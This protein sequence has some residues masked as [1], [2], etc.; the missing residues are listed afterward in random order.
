MGLKYQAAVASSDATRLFAI[1]PWDSNKKSPT[2]A[3]GLDFL[4]SFL[5]ISGLRFGPFWPILDLL[6]TKKSI[7]AGLTDFG[8]QNESSG[9]RLQTI[10]RSCSSEVLAM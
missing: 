4:G 10:F 3:E 9:A 2:R 8:A 6:D 1:H 7:P 5:E